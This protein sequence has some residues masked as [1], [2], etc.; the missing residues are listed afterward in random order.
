[1]GF[2]AWILE[3]VWHLVLGLWDLFGIWCLEFGIC[4]SFGAWD[5]EFISI[6]FIREINSLNHDNAIH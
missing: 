5:L 3:F 4:L 1:L 2:V 6:T